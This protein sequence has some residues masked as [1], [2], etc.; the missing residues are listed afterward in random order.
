MKTDTLKEPTIESK[1]SHYEVDVL[2]IKPL[3]RTGGNVRLD[4]G[5]KD[6]T[7]QELKDSIAENGIINPI[8]AYRDKDIEGGWIAIDGHRRLKASQQLV[9]E[10]SVTIR[11]RIIVVDMRKISDEQLVID[12]VIS[13]TGKP[14]SPLELSEAVRRLI[15]YGYK[16]KDVAVKFSMPIQAIYNFNLLSTAPKRIRDLIT[17]NRLSYTT[18]LQILKTSGDFNEAIE[19]IEKALT[20]ANKENVGVESTENENAKITRKHLN[21]ATNKVDSCI[22]LRK[23]FKKQIDAQQ[24]IKNQ[25][26][27]SFAKKIIENKLTSSD[28]EKLL[29]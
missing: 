23:V 10:K 2:L 14:L 3:E 27:Y 22:E 20:I 13:N 15:S 24:T 29:F 1:Q 12:M 17:N 8:R 11:A 5:E 7:F 6:G 16:P 4:Y 9:E 19:K 18:A 26:L 25:E 28:I 21:E